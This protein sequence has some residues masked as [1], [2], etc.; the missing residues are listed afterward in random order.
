MKKLV[1]IV[2]PIYRYLIFAPLLGL[3]TVFW[4]TM[5]VLIAALGKQRFASR[6][7]GG[8]W[9][10]S[11]GFF[12]PMSVHV[13]GR[14]NIVDGRS[15]VVVLNHPSA[16][17]IFLV[18]G[19]LGID[20]KWVIKKEARKIPVIGKSCE[21]LGHIFVDRGN[22]DAAIASLEEAKSK[23]V[24]GMSVV[25]FPEG[26]RSPKGSVSRFKKGAFRMAMQLNLPIL[27]V[28]ILGTDK[29]LPNKTTQLYPGSAKMIIHPAIETTGLEHRDMPTL[30]EKT[31]LVIEAPLLEG[32]PETENE[33]AAVS[34]QL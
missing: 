8:M 13:S 10:R 9:A 28:T 11:C 34:S 6:F 29:I 12:T 30:V 4:G 20:F 3:A 2:Y 14:E 1:R 21:Q 5:A 23:V 27:P 31:R 17:D 24:E 32:K 16:Y 19:W 22:T 25:F 33:L 15:Y 7:S 26:T 18:Y